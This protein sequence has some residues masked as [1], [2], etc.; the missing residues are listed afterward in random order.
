MSSWAFDGLF[1]HRQKS[2]QTDSD[3]T[4]SKLGS[5][6]LLFSFFAFFPVKLVDKMFNFMIIDVF[7]ILQMELRNL[8]HPLA[9]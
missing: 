9:T 1:T 4:P 2:I 6:P 7:P 8:T 5:S 3:Y